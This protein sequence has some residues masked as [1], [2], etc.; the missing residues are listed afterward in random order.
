MGDTEGAAYE[1]AGDV[2]FQAID[3]EAVLLS[4]TSQNYYTLNSSAARMWQLLLE[5][6][7]PEGVADRLCG[8]YEVERDR[9]L[10]DVESLARGLCDAGLLR[11][12]SQSL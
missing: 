11:V 9:A 6:G 3:G 5:C 2:L 12:C 4:L 7:K 1:A 8:E 10:N